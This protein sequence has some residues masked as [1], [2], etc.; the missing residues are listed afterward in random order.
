METG[1][2]WSVL[3][4]AAD[5]I[6]A[7]LIAGRL[8]EEDIPSFL[9]KDRTGYGDYLLGGS[10]AHAP[11]SVLVPEDRLAEAIELLAEDE[12]DPVLNAGDRLEPGEVE[13]LARG[14]SAFGTLRTLR[15]WIG[16]VV[17]GVMVWMLLVENPLRDLLDILQKR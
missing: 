6:D 13:V 15:G 2:E 14:S 1:V 16:V 9:D 10:N 3:V 8:A 4:V 12:P 11:V 17:V 7:Q 5:D